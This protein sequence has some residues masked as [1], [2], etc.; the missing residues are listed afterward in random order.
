[1]ALSLRNVAAADDAIKT[2]EKVL[3]QL[4][5]NAEMARKEHR[6]ANAELEDAEKCRRAALCFADHDI[7]NEKE[8]VPDFNAKRLRTVQERTSIRCTK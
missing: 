7:C 5:R 8:S 6:E 3:E 2:A 4:R 1:M